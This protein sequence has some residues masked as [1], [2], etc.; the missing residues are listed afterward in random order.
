MVPVPPSTAPELTTTDPVP[1]PLPLVFITS[2]VPP[3]TV[4]VPVYELPPD[5]GESVKVPV[6]ALVR[7]PVPLTT[8]P[9]V[10][11]LLLPPVVSVIEL[12]VTLPPL[13]PSEP[14]V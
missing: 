10:V 12:R 6:P 11:E 8:P 4:V 13:P 14:I 7:P 2:S 5:D 1:G 9:K 3:A